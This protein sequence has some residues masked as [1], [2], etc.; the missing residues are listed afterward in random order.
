M[1]VPALRRRLKV[2]ALA[3]C[4]LAL[5]A[6]SR[7]YAETC[8]AAVPAEY[9]KYFI[10]CVD[11][12]SFPEKVLN[13]F[14]WTKEDIGRSFALVAGVARYPRLTG[15]DRYLEPAA[16]DVI[17]MVRYLRDIEFFDE[18]VVLENEAVSDEN[19]KFFLQAYFPGRLKAI[20]RS[21][22]L[23]AYSGHGFTDGKRGYL[24]QA[25]ARSFDDKANSISMRIVETLYEEIIDSAYQSLAL[26]N[27]CNSGD[28]HKRPFGATRRLVPRAPGHHVITAGGAGE[29]AWHDDNIGPGSIFFEKLFAGLGGYA[30][31]SPQQP[32][33]SLGD[34]VISAEELGLYLRKEV[35]IETNQAQN[36]IS[37]DISRNG[38]SGSFFFLGRDRQLK[39]GTGKDFD[40]R[41]ATRMGGPITELDSAVPESAKPRLNTCLVPIVV[42]PGSAAIYLDGKFVG[43]G[44]DLAPPGGLTIV[45]GALHR[46]V[47]VRPGFVSEEKSFRWEQCSEKPISFK[48]RKSDI[49]SWEDIVRNDRRETKSTGDASRQQPAEQVVDQ[50]GFRVSLKGCFRS[51]PALRCELVVTNREEDRELTLSSGRL[52]DKA[53]N[54]HAAVMVGFGADMGYLRERSRLPT[55]I[56]SRAQVKFENVGPGVKLLALLELEL[57]PPGRAE[58]RRFGVFGVPRVQ[59]RSVIIQEE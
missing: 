9:R 30:D 23:F 16:V 17:N 44:I 45:S 59:F 8:P 43:A 46:V 28:F 36:P 40:S 24:V 42:D 41:Q 51:G 33:G 7:A 6:I 52:I 1:N 38:S 15:G 14:S 49:L 57:E 2:V 37:S 4:V 18:I 55:G 21:R 19:L 10:H 32:D 54:E 39:A 48:L 13:F 31:L 35:Q 58:G 20:P 11:Q 56:S 5:V 29:A 26:I 53:G 3:S 12:R 34:G 50:L 22:F 47:V 27:A 25:Q